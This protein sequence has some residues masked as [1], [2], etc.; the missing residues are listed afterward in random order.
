[1]KGVVD[2]GPVIALA[3]IDRIELLA[4]L[5]QEAWVP[6][7]VVHEVLAKPG[8]ETRRIETALGRFLRVAVPPFA[9]APQLEPFLRRLD[10]GERT[11]IALAGRLPPPVT[12]VMDDA[13]GRAVARRVGLP[14]LGFAGLLMVAKERGLIETVVPSLAAARAQ[15]YWLDD[16]LIEAV[17]RLANE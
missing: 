10:E 16:A 11:V 9:S 14:V 2:A 3:K 6:E 4:S 17:R 5:F 13:A 8:R 12:V 15:G 1:M 7:T